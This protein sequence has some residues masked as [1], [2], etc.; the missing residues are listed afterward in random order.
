MSSTQTYLLSTKHTYH[1]SVSHALLFFLKISLSYI[2]HIDAILN[3]S[4]FLICHIQAITNSVSTFSLNY[5][6][7]I[8]TSLHFQLIM[9]VR[10]A[11]LDYC[12]VLTVLPNSTT[13]LLQS[14]RHMAAI[15]IFLKCNYYNLMLLH[16]AI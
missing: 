15:L 3:S 16:K 11:T 6:L 14:T 9:P 8:S 13:A 12:L 2:W 5:L 1:L 10:A 7:N 4:L